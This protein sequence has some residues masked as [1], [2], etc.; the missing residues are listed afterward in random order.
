M[1][2]NYRLLFSPLTLKND[3]CP[4]EDSINS[5]F[6]V[7]ETFFGKI[8]HEALHPLFFVI[9]FLLVEEPNVSNPKVIPRSQC[10]RFKTHDGMRFGTCKPAA[11]KILT[12]FCSFQAFFWQASFFWKNSGTS[13]GEFISLVLELW[14]Q[15]CNGVSLNMTQ[16]LLCKAIHGF[17]ASF[18]VFFQ[19]YCVHC[20]FKK[21]NPSHRGLTSLKK[22]QEKENK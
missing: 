7:K 2:F 20:C 5:L 3:L 16:F 11:L 6:K 13:N 10:C 1:L 18:C 12:L 8:G 17:L 4:S 9:F 19:L 21:A 14:T 15:K 22:K